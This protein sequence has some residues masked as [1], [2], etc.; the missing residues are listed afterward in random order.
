MRAPTSLPLAARSWACVEV[1]IRLL[2]SIGRRRVVVVRAE[3]ERHAPVR[4]RRFGIQGRRTLER[5]K[6]L[7]VI[8][9][10]E[11]RQ[12][13]VEEPLR[14]GNDGRDGTVVRAK[15]AEKRRSLRRRCLADGRR[16][17]PLARNRAAYRPSRSLRGATAAI[18]SFMATT[19]QAGTKRSPHLKAGS[20]RLDARLGPR[21]SVR[22]TPA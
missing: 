10:V 18:I 4:H 19:E 20:L 21:V 15:V 12:A 5:P 1:S 6:R 22:D 14:V 8:E 9:A 2:Q 16:G 3:R 7:L 13:L 17:Q 11:E